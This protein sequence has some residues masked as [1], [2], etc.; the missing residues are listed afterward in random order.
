MIFLAHNV[1]TIKT[2]TLSDLLQPNDRLCLHHVSLLNFLLNESM[3]ELFQGQKK[4]ST[5]A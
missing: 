2:L 1:I 3:K 5:D 4:N